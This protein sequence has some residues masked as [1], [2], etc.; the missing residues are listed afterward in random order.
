MPSTASTTYA[1]YIEGKLIAAIA[2]GTTTGVTIKIKQINMAT[3]TWP[4]AAHRIKIVQRTATNNKVEKIQVAAGTTQSGTTVTLGTL[5]RALPLSNGT[6]FTGS[7][8]AQAFAAG[9]DVFLSWDSHD[10]A[11]SA[12]LDL[13]NTFTTHQ[14]ISSTNELRL[15]DSATAIWDDGTDLNFK[16]SAQATRTL[17]QLAAL[18][19]SNDKF[20][21]SSD[22]TTENYALNKLTGGDGI[23]VTETSGGGNETLDFDVDL[24][25]DPGLEFNSGQLRVKAS[26]GITRDSNGV[27][28][29]TTSTALRSLAR[30]FGDGSDGTK[31]IAASEDLDPTADWHY[32][33]F[34]L[35]ASQ[36]MSVSS[37]NT[38]LVIR[39]LGDATINGTINLDGKGGAGTAGG[40]AG[41][42][43]NAATAGT[44]LA[45]A[46][47]VGAGGAATSV[48]NGRGGGGGASLFTA[49][50]AGANSGGSA[51]ATVSTINQLLLANI[52][53]LVGC[54]GGGSGGG[55]DSDSNDSTAGSAGGGAML[56]Y[57]GGNLTLG[58]S[59]VITADSANTSDSTDGGSGGTGGGGTVVIVVGGSITNSGVSCTA[60]AGTP[61]TAGSGST[62][63]AGG[64]GKIIIY[65]L[66]DNTVISA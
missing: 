30:W 26:T 13:A 11:Q 5:T 36:V 58:A 31:T 19:G 14:T 22:D 16:S 48:E 65:S 39:V 53:I 34:T 27:S 43:S 21:I 33:A 1:D 64:A 32:T 40:T 52:N 56:M 46:I 4:T 2:T 7:G 59:S 49:G 6:D 17:S 50:T 3:P 47:T 45:S 12:K 41:V 25:T 9:A 20:K 51:G 38:P 29:D 23:S 61:G 63:G 35:N 15:A 57:V 18:S 8:T 42:G 28:V 55:G 62:G 37:V 44:T 24:A 60:T 54:G 10:A 66:L